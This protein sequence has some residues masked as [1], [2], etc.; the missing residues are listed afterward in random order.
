MPKSTNKFSA[1]AS[2]QGYLYQCL[3]ALCESLHRLRKGTEFRVSLETLDDVVFEK[4]GEVKD[5]LQNKHHID[6]KAVD[7]PPYNRTTS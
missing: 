6:K 7:L 2:M 5:L 1:S 3:Y 4:N